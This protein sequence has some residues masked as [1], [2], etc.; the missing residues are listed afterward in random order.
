MKGLGLQIFFDT[1]LCTLA[2]EAGLLDA[3]ERGDLG[4]DQSGIETDHAEVEISTLN[5]GWL[6]G[7]VDLEELR[8]Q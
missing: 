8:E 5:V 7:E 2:A 4:G 3:A 1:D 6:T